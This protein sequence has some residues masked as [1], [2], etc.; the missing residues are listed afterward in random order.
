M[1]ELMRSCVTDDDVKAIMKK[2]LEQ[3]K[4]GDG[5]ARKFLFDYFAGVPVQRHDVTT[6]DEPLD[7]VRLFLPDNGRDRTIPPSG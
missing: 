4:R 2:A 3:A 7:V 6:D 5:Q 1:V